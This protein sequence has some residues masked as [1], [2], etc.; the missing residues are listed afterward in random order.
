[1]PPGGNGFDTPG[2]GVSKYAVLPF[3]GTFS[4]NTLK[5]ELENI[6]APLYLPVSLNAGDLALELLV[7]IACYPSVLCPS[8]PG[9]LKSH[10]TSRKWCRSTLRCRG[11]RSREGRCKCPLRCLMA[12]QSESLQHSALE[13]AAERG[14]RDQI[15]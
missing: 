6:S 13:A 9:Q 14:Q 3:R 1:M 11:R 4:E 8:S 2:L 5:H 15:L 7:D 12:L 10:I